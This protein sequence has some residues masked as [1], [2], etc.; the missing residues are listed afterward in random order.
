MSYTLYYKVYSLHEAPQPVYDAIGTRIQRQPI[1]NPMKILLLNPPHPSIGSRIPQEHLPPLGLL[2]LA[3]PLL[4]AGHRVGLLD[5][6]FGPM[7][8]DSIVSEVRAHAPDAVLFGHSGST[9]GHP[10]AARIARAVRAAVPHAWII[11]GGVFPTYHWFELMEQE[12]GI[13]FIVR[14][15]GEET[16]VR[17]VAALERRQAWKRYL[18][19]CSARTPSRLQG[20]RM[21]NGPFRSVR[22]W[23]LPRRR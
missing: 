8:V 7:T 2:A 5:A 13:D 23:R 14:G 18:G 16:V 1:A 20:D 21:G 15:E 10:V 19:S 4:D 17:L 6:E 9:S 22:L 3:G 11:Y 12:P